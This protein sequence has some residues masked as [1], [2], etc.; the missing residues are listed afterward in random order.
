M[1]A[2]PEAID[3]HAGQGVLALRWADGRTVRW[4]H[5]DL[6]VACPCAECRARRRAGQAVEAAAELRIA[7]I[8]PVGA[9][10]LNLAFADGHRRG[11]YPFEMLAGSPN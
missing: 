6:R 1:S 5:A 8:E 9:Y 2:L 10:A 3:N 4:T 7:A 11:I